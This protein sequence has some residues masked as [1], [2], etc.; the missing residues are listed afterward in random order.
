MLTQF[1]SA[2]MVE[3]NT[4]ENNV[5]VFEI[6]SDS[7]HDHLVCQGCGKVVEFHNQSIETEQQRVAEANGFELTDHA[8]ILYGLCAECQW[9]GFKST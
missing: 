4:F 8:L 1:E 3:R 9:G 2:G 5:S 7:H 6:A